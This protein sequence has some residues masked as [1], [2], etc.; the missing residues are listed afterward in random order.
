MVDTK[1]D[2]KTAAQK[3]PLMAMVRFFDSDA[4]QMNL[5]IF[6]VEWAALSD[7]DRAQLKAGFSDKSLSYELTPEQLEAARASN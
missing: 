1:A 4:R 5:Q 2:A 7:L 3:S 6:K